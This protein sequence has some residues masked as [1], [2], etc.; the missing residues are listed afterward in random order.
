M[1]AIE[2]GLVIGNG[3]DVSE[4]KDY[5]GKTLQNYLSKVQAVVQATHFEKLC[6]WEKHAVEGLS[7]VW[8]YGSTRPLVKEKRF[9]W[10]QETGWSVN[11]NECPIFLS[12]NLLNGQ[13]VMFWY[14][15]GRK[16]DYDAIEA[17]FAK[18]LPA[19]VQRAT[20]D[21]FSEVFHLLERK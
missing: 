7:S 4:T 10:R 17:W 20:A 14:P 19:S 13:R 5:T 8:M 12:F 3:D 16:V 18:N 1:C 6:L 15:T 11:A 2:R 21:S 9:I